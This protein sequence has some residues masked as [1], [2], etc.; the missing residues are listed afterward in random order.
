MKSAQELGEIVGMT[1]DGVNDAPGAE[2]GGR[3]HCGF[4]SDGGGA[5]GGALILTAP[6]LSVI[7]RGIEEARRPSSA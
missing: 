7:I 5:C 3:R 4:G 1:G 2:T 6:G